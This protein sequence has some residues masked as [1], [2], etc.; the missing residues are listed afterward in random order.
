MRRYNKDNIFL[1]VEQS[2]ECQNTEQHAKALIREAQ[3][4]GGYEE[5]EISMVMLIGLPKSYVAY[6][7][8]MKPSASDCFILGTLATLAGSGEA[9]SNILD[10]AESLDY[11]EFDERAALIKHDKFI[12]FLNKLSVSIQNGTWT[13]TNQATKAENQLCVMSEYRSLE[14]IAA[15]SGAITKAVIYKFDH[16]FY[17]LCKDTSTEFRLSVSN[18]SKQFLEEHAK[19]VCTVQV[20]REVYKTA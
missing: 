4:L 9:V 2:C 16:H 18:K 12:E 14:D 10:L 17:T 7:I 6:V 5:D 3:E 1:F 8:L 11:S 13:D 15:D 20:L 19:V